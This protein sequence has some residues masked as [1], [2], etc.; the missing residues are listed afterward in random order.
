MTGNL[1]FSNLA[2]LPFREQ[3][4]DEDS[5]P[6]AGPHSIRRI[7]PNDRPEGL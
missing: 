5:G 1:I 7:Y 3:Y 6:F 2:Y 4:E